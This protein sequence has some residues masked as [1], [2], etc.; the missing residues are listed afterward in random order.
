MKKVLIT[1]SN[2]QV[3]SYMV[4]YL[5]ENTDNT[6][7]AA[8]R[9]TSQP[10]L[11]HLQKYQA[12]DRVKFITLDLSDSCSIE[13]AIKEESPD[14]FINFGASAFVPDSWN[15]PAYTIQVNTIS[16]INI[17][18]AIRKFV[19][20]CRFYNACSSE[21]F[22]EVLE[23]PQKETTRPNPR[24]IYGVSKNAAREVVKVYRDSYDLYAVSGILFNHESPR[25]QE[26]YVTR[27]ITKNVARIAKSIEKNEEFKPLQLGNLDAERDWS[28]ARDFVDGVWKMLHQDDT[29]KDYVLSSNETHCI[30]EFVEVA[31]ANA[32]I[33]KNKCF[34]AGKG[35]KEKYYLY[36]EKGVIIDKLPLVEINPEFYRPAEVE[37]L[38]GDSSEARKELKWNPK[39]DFY[40]LV[41][42]MVNSDITSF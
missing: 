32:G 11:N 33:P 21:I 6:I 39:I 37:L 41:E 2:G 19:P 15:M 42:E 36:T 14:Y 8:T 16:V 38:L 24:S 29:I 10:I 1:G 18:E 30:R 7:I 23:T 26:H 20:Q 25:R 4:D 12:D 28:D 31:F 13:K 3:G 17:L 34:W 9:R 22:G 27:K 35:V 40:N 5:Y